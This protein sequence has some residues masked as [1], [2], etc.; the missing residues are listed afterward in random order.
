MHTMGAVAITG[1][2]YIERVL[3]ASAKSSFT[4]PANKVH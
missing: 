3:Q 1:Q 4:L 2:M